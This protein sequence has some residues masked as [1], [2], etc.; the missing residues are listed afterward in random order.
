MQ[1]VL[2][3]RNLRSIIIA[4]H[5]RSIVWMQFWYKCIVWI[6]FLIILRHIVQDG[7]ILD[8]AIAYLY[9][10]PIIFI[11]HSEQFCMEFRQYYSL[12][13]I[14]LHVLRQDL[15]TFQTIISISHKKM[16]QFCTIFRVQPIPTPL[17]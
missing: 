17:R 9:T 4:T 3:I 13:L 8:I 7:Q 1:C 10:F 2:K 14:V 16:V 12:I 5:T 6:Q 15:Y 11:S